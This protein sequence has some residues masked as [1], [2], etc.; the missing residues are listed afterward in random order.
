MNKVVTTLKNQGNTSAA[1]IP[2]AL[3]YAV[4]KGDVKEGDTIISEAFGSGFVGVVYCKN[5]II[6][7]TFKIFLNLININILINNKG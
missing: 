3:D 7:S 6:I 4:R 5:I 1:S 2:L